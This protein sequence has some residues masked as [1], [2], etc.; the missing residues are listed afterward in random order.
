LKILVH[1]TSFQI[2]ANIDERLKQ[3]KN[4]IIVHSQPLFS[5]RPKPSGVVLNEKKNNTVYKN[6]VVNGVILKVQKGTA[7]Y[8][9]NP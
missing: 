7:V 1:E 5:V 4:K 9:Q 6:D 2:T 8:K 3:R